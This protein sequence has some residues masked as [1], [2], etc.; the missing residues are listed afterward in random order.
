MFS[1]LLKELKSTQTPQKGNLG[2]SFTNSVLNFRLCFVVQ[3]TKNKYIMHK[4]TNLKPVYITARCK[5]I[6]S[7]IYIP[8]CSVKMSEIKSN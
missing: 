2:V 1:D 8:Y 4:Y 6:K 7:K 3:C 5:A